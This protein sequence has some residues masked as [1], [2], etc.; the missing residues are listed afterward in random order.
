LAYL[1]YGIA[2][3]ATGIAVSVGIYTTK[4]ATCLWALLFPACIGISYGKNNKE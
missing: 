2:W 3:L 4:D 1:A